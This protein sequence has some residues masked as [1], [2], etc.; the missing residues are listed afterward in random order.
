MSPKRVAVIERD[1]K[2]ENILAYFMVDI[3]AESKR[4][5]FA[6]QTVDMMLGFVAPEFSHKPWNYYKPF[7]DILK[8]NDVE[9]V[10]FSYKDHRFG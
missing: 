8:K 3:E 7:L 1:M 9:N 5:C 6:A 2:L 10:L 4:D